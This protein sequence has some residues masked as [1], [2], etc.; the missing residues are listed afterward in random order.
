MILFHGWNHGYASIS[1][2]RNQD[3]EDIY[4]LIKTLGI[5]LVMQLA[6][7]LIR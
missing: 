2:F 7:E 3:L 6:N 5:D 1:C 4:W